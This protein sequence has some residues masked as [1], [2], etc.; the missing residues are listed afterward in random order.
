[1]GLYMIRA[2]IRDAIAADFNS[3]VELNDLEVH[4]T[5][6]MDLERLNSLARIAC[7][8]RVAVAED[9][10]IAFLLAMR[11]GVPYQN[12]NYSWFASRFQHF[13]YVD[14]VVVDTGFARLSIGSRMYRDL[15]EYAHAKGIKSI[16]CEYNIEP[17]NPASRAFHRKLGFKEIAI[18]WVANNTKLVSLQAAET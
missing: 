11:E 14:R 18:Q 5:S 13:I 17:P 10:V 12:D 7:Y 6:P 1:M 8:H 9:R 2:I 15:F 4:Q 16:T 3:I